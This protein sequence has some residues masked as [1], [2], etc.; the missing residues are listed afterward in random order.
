MTERDC[1]KGE[2]YFSIL[3]GNAERVKHMM[4]TLIGLLGSSC[5]SGGKVFIPGRVS[6]MPARKDD[7]VEFM[8]SY[9]SLH[10][11]LKVVYDRMGELEKSFIREAVHNPEGV[12]LREQFRAK[13][14]G[15]P[16][17]S[18]DVFGARKVPFVCFFTS[19]RGPLPADLRE[20]LLAFVPP[21]E[22]LKCRVLDNPAPEPESLL[23]VNAAIPGQVVHETERA[24]LHD[25]EAVL[26]LVE[27][28]RISVS[29]NTGRVT[30]KGAEAVREVL[31]CG[32]FYPGGMEAEC[33]YDVRMGPA[34]IR[35]FAW[36]MILQAGKLARIEGSKL[37]LK[38]RTASPAH[39]LLS[40]LWDSWLG[41]NVL[42]E[43]SR[44]DVIKGQKSRGRP[45]ASASVC[46][47]AVADALSEMPEGKW[48]ELGEFF[49][50]LT[51]AGHGFD[52][53]RDAWSLYIA[54]SGYGSLGYSHITWEHLSGRF[55]RAFLLEYAAVM[56]VVDVAVV[57]PWGALDDFRDLWG[58]DEYS[59]LSRYDGLRYIRLT[60]L[61]AWVLGVRSGYNPER[62]I[63]KKSLFKLLPNLDIIILARELMPSDRLFLERVSVQKSERVW[64]ISKDNIV[65]SVAKGLKPEL[66]K[67]FLV[68]AGEGG[69]PE[70]AE[71]FLKDIR[72]RIEK[73]KSIEP[74]I[75]I[76]CD[77]RPTAV[78]LSNDSRLGKLCKFAEDRHLIVREKD[79][80]KFS[81]LLKKAG[82]VL[83]GGRG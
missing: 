70:A 74:C 36:P 72:S 35:P 65:S 82:Y 60:P 33:K 52:V 47:E 38:K 27:E 24:A 83:P 9:L 64:R 34:G 40:K 12:V 29:R 16:D 26:H 37:V 39:E 8:M 7:M 25:I 50:Y 44:V 41:S 20:R 53:A 49:R 68:S 15:V 11:V 30:E 67:D 81:R 22:A 80:N 51:A 6:P 43:M 61:G 31:L 75:M 14:G 5:D 58:S 79:R 54:E 63:G 4:R 19:G 13:Y 73:L 66:I 56:G 28:G 57:P 32:D 59:C 45:L 48:V 76:E 77:G 18:I 1:I 42:H 21:P 46:R 71:V 2:H 23:D 62:T 10:D 55:A 17:F 69:L 78:L 3:E